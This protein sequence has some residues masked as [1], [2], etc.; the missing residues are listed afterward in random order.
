[1]GS[2]DTTRST[3][4]SS[5]T[6]RCRSATAASGVA[7]LPM[8][9]PLIVAGVGCVVISA[10]KPEGRGRVA[11]ATEMGVWV[12]ILDPWAVVTECHKGIVQDPVMGSTFVRAHGVPGSGCRG[13]GVPGSGCR[14]GA[15]TGSP[16]VQGPGSRVQGPGSRVRGPET[17][18]I[19]DGIGPQA[20]PALAEGQGYAPVASRAI[21]R[22]RALATRESK[23]FMLLRPRFS[24]VLTIFRTTES[25]LPIPML[26]RC[27]V[28]L[29]IQAPSKLRAEHTMPRPKKPP[30]TRT[31]RS[32]RISR[33]F[34]QAEL[35]RRIR[36]DRSYISM[37][38]NGKREGMSTR[39]LLSLARA[40][41]CTADELLG[42]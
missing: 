19:R 23:A 36:C 32:L 3:L 15:A 41:E 42:T 10:A 30:Y 40:L 13:A 27:H 5:I 21:D 22:P 34:S 24:S 6:R 14:G 39:L 26:T 28:P 33:G 2:A 17:P 25:E 35:A 12:F 1:M 18:G 4:L 7:P 38:E 37:L 9:Q 20:A 31:L 8:G 16:G 29:S 11:T